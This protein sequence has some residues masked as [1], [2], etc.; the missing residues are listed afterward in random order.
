MPASGY[1]KKWFRK[2]PP[3]MQQYYDKEHL[4]YEKIPPHNPACERIFQ[5]GGP[6]V[7][8][9]LNCN[10]YLISKSSREP[11][12][13]S[14]RTGTDV[15]MVYWYINNK[16]YKATQAGTTAYFI[17]QEGPVKI[18]CSDD[19]GRNKDIQIWVRYVNL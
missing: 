13:L 11:L 19:K 17:P 7:T 10:E 4:A 18:S 14:C 12:Q 15:S 1:R 2:L 6:I 16:F 9:P 8:S 5:E 3:E